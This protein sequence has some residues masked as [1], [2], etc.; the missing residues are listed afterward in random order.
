MRD[1]MNAVADLGIGIGH[2]L[3]LEAAVDR[4]PG[5]AA[6]VGAKRAGGGDGDED[7]LVDWSDRGGSCAAPCR[8]RRAPI[9]APVPWPR[10]PASSCQSG[11]RRSIGTARR[12][13]RRRRPCSG[14]VSDG[15]RCQTRLNSHGC[16]V[17]SYHWCVV[18]GLPVG[19]RV[20]DELVALALG[21]AFGR[22]G[23]LAGRRAG[24]VPGFAAVVGA[25]D[26]LPEPAAG[27]RGVD[28]VRIDRRALEV[29]NLPAGEVRPADLPLLAL[30]VGGE[31]E[32]AFLGADE[33]A[34]GGH[35]LSFWERIGVL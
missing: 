8:R 3:R 33:D 17:P 28:A 35:R 22:G 1:A 12:L 11:R 32:R 25:L 34:D 16:C 24:L 15:S 4:L 7:A 5:L 23:R 26:D 10:R 2:V 27:L 29:I 31:N 21:H 19:G 6:V 9:S 20:V 18:S 14:S 13:P 30:A